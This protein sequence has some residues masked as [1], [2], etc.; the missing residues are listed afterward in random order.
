MSVTCRIPYLEVFLW[1]KIM[2]AM[3]TPNKPT[4][5]KHKNNFHKTIFMTKNQSNCIIVGRR[6]RFYFEER[7]NWFALR[8]FCDFVL[9]CST[10][11][12]HCSY[13][14][15]ICA[16]YLYLPTSYAL[17]SEY[18][19]RYWNISAYTDY[20]LHIIFMLNLIYI[21][22]VF[23]NENKIIKKILFIVTMLWL[24]RHHFETC[25]YTASGW[26]GVSHTEKI[27]VIKI[28]ITNY[29]HVYSTVCCSYILVDI[30]MKNTN[31]KNL[32]KLNL[33][34]FFF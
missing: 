1:I 33:F 14:C 8:Y 4:Y 23:K 34:F 29:H 27:I 28:M 16:K 17:H 3:G 30:E 24:V 5:F 12:N 21:A 19:D 18:G 13:L 15:S 25:L 26:C 31:R 32:H 20:W 9:F 11:N 6:V 2:N 22:A 10:K 7:D